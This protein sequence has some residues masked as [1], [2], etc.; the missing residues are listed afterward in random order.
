MMNGGTGPQCPD[1]DNKSLK[2]EYHNEKCGH[3]ST[4]LSNGFM[5]FMQTICILDNLN[6]TKNGTSFH[7]NENSENIKKNVGVSYKGDKET[8][9]YLD[10]KYNISGPD[11]YPETWGLN[12]RAGER[13][14]SYIKRVYSDP[15]LRDSFC[16][17]FEECSCEYMAK[18]NKVLKTF[19]HTYYFSV[20][21]GERKK[22]REKQRDVFNHPNKLTNSFVGFDS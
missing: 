1:F 10:S 12:R 3:K 17:G 7:S 9:Q 19:E 15:I 4:W 16:T 20:A 14:S 6:F 8:I 13:I 5:R 18:M 2:C 21:T 22:Q 11:L